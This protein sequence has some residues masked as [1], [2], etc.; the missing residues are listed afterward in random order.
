[1]TQ[2]DPLLL[3]PLGIRGLTLKN[4][5]VVSPMCQHSAVDGFIQ[6][7]HVI[8]YG[9]FAMGGAAL[10]FTESTAVS[11]DSRIGVSDL[12]IWSD[13]HIPGLRRV[14]DFAHGQNACF[15]VQLAHA[16]RKSFSEPLWE[17][18]RP[19][20]PEQMDA[21]GLAWRRVGPSAIRAG[22]AWSVPAAL[23]VNEI[24]DIQQQFVDAAVRA[25]KAGA[26]VVELHFGHGYLVASFLSRRSNLRQDDY[27]GPLENRMRLAVEIAT[28]VR[29]VWP[30]EKPLFARLSCLDGAADS[31]EMEDTVALAAAL[32]AVGV[33]VIDCSSG[34]FSEQVRQSNVPRGLGFQVHFAEEIRE[35]AGIMTQ[36]VG[37]I[38]TPQQAEEILQCGQAD[39][40]AI[41]RA[42]L[43]NPFWPAEARRALIDSEDF[44]GW[45]K[46]HRDWLGR[47]QKSLHSLGIETD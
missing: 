30:A 1:M 10:F 11:S 7:W 14:A 6:D 45:P 25:E 17:G 31:W 46:Q 33:D 18:G 5:I 37:I 36:A 23:T 34:G 24:H 9:K 42:A 43:R 38:L 16:G 13:D 4:R 3:R 22:E 40:I 29:A 15:G 12:G 32:K 27:G 26:D 39:L 41:G 47:R 20:S 2:P 35:K 19:L 28:Q 21:A 8:H 44:S